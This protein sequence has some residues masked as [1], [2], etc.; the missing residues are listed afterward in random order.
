MIELHCHLDGSLSVEDVLTLSEMTGVP[1][2]TKEKDVLFSCLTYSG[3]GTLNDYLEK[4]RLPLSLLQS[5]ESVSFALRS[6]S[7]RLFSCGC[8]YAE[9]RFAPALHLLGGATMREIV[10]GAVKGLSEAKIPLGILLCAMRGHSEEENI[11]VMEL[12]AEWRGKGVVGVDLAGAEALYPTEGYKE[13]FSLASR[14]GLNVTIHAGEAAGADS[15]RAALDFG[16]KRI[17]HGVAAAKDEALLE[18]IKRE[19]IVLEV[20]PT[21]NVQTSAVSSIERHPVARFLDEGLRLAICS[22]NMTV[23]NTDVKKEC[24]KVKAAFPSRLAKIERAISE[25]EHYA[26]DRRK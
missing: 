12:A 14:F 5:A 1:L 2:P 8:T 6:L 7:E 20:C 11:S 13:V 4:F 19:G 18:R 10:Q 16:A 23:S 24:E 17:G 3:V 9:I 21:S 22:D 26:F 15:V 25:A